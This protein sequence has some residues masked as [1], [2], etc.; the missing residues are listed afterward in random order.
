MG[1]LRKEGTF[2]NFPVSGKFP[3]SIVSGLL[4][5]GARYGPIN[6]TD[7]L[8]ANLSMSCFHH[9]D[10]RRCDH[11]LVGG[12]LTAGARNGTDVKHFWNRNPNLTDRLEANLFFFLHNRRSP[13]STRLSHI[14]EKVIANCTTKLVYLRIYIM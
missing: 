8:E 10:A 4:T 9:V 7:R 3:L 1:L 11:G 2:F 13:A 5:A 6:L 14:V 12:L